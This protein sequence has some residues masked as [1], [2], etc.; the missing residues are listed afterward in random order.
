MKKIIIFSNQ[1]RDTGLAVTNEIDSIIKNDGIDTF[2]CRVDS[3]GT[4]VTEETLI[5]E[6]ELSKA[7]MIITVGGDG[8]ILHA[9]A[10]AAWADIPILGV[11]CGTVGFMAELEASELSMIKNIL[12]KEFQTDDRM[13][14]DIVVQRD[15]QSVFSNIALNDAVVSKGAVA[16][17]IPISVVKDGLPLTKFSAD[18]VVIATPTGS[19]AYS[20]AAGGPIVESTANNILITPICAHSMYAK[21][22]VLPGES[23]IAVTI[24]GPKNKM[25]Y[26]SVDGGKAFELEEQDRILIKRSE[27]KTRLVRVK[28][29]S[30]Y[31]VIYQK[32]VKND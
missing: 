25:A 31:D 10:Q 19:T 20:M 1:Q 15:G 16:R 22:F 7:C 21:P 9:A 11:N 23:E 29:W 26:I 28:D 6:E 17:I 14:L 13:M 8:T 24:S 27:K 18:G 32:L 4:I 12:H 30:F 2:I 5:P 3:S